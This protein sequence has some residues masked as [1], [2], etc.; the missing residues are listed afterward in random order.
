MLRRINAAPDL[1]TWPLIQMKGG[2]RG[3]GRWLNLAKV[4]LLLRH[5]SSSKFQLPVESKFHFIYL[6][7][8]VPLLWQLVLRNCANML[9]LLFKT[10]FLER[11]L[12]QHVGR[13]EYT[14]QVLLCH[15]DAFCIISIKL[16]RNANQSLKRRTGAKGCWQLKNPRGSASKRSRFLFISCWWKALLVT[17]IWAALNSHWVWAT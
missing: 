11:E 8:M 15:S 9:H 17:L 13:G 14:F 2:L 12:V 7:V 10:A 6:M 1:K 3:P 5:W 4:L 16:N